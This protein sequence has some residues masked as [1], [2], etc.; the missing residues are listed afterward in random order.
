MSAA[1]EFVEVV[2]AIEVIDAAR[3][4]PRMQKQ[5]AKELGAVRIALSL[6]LSAAHRADGDARPNRP[7]RGAG[8]SDEEWA[9]F[10]RGWDAHAQAVYASGLRTALHSIEG[11]DA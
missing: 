9:I 3:F 7:E 1:A 10:L 2:N 8:Y 6:L 4:C 5:I 11:G